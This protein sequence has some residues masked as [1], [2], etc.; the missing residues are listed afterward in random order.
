[1]MTIK[2]I[3]KKGASK[4]LKSSNISSRQAQKLSKAILELQST[5]LQQLQK[6]G[7]VRKINVPNAENVYAF[8]AGLSERILF[9]SVDGKVMIHDIVDVKNDNSVK[10]FIFKKNK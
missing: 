9:S 6:M 3:I 10:S 7:K 2:A 8:R 5:E 1:M 4:G